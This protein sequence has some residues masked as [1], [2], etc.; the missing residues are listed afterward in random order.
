M[1]RKEPDECT[2]Y[3]GKTEESSAVCFKCGITK[4][5]IYDYVQYESIQGNGGNGKVKI[6][7]D[8]S[9]SFPGATYNAKYHINERLAQVTLTGPTIPDKVME[10]ID[11]YYWKEHEKG[12]Y[13]NPPELTKE[14]ISRL[15]NSVPIPESMQW[16]FKSVKK[17]KR[18]FTSCS[19]FSERWYLI[20]K[21]LGGLV[22]PDP[23]PEEITLLKS[24]CFKAQS[25][26]N[27]VRHTN[28]CKEPGIYC[29]TKYG[30]RKNFPS[31]YYVMHQLC[32]M[33]KLEHLLPLF[34]VTNKTCTVRKLNKYWEDICNI[35][36]WKFN[37]L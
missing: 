15:C 9:V 23:T 13:P 10:L 1:K 2:H 25:Q 35:L 24:Y 4:D 30:C 12:N 33:L 32:L 11:E 22:E 3:W 19:K 17:K 36:G 20:K 7:T 21:E 27:V 14:D 31:I 6:Q 34:P 16:E 26:W 37:A 28:K 8:L 18:L 5:A 29:H